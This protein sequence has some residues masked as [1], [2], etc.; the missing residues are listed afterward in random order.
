[1]VQYIDNPAGRLEKLLLDLHAAY[2]NDQQQNHKQAWV[3]V[4]ELINNAS[5]LAAQVQIVG[6]VVALPAEIRESV[7]QL[8]VDDD[9]KEHLLSH[10]VEIEQGMIALLN[11]QSLFAVFNCFATNGIVPRSAAVAALSH[12]SYELHR[13]APEVVISDDDLARI[14][15]M[16]NELMAE[17]AE[18]KLPDVVKRAM[19]NH[20]VALLQAAY[21]VRFAGTQPLDDALFAL[22]G[23]IGRTNGREDLVRVGLWEKFQRAVQA[24]N[25]ML[26]TGQTAAQLGQGI[27]GFL[28]S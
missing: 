9:R 27:A 15:E 20:L 18:A 16:I 5:G 6:A 4:V 19:L 12:C 26:S 8:P 14:I 17:V 10:L 22:S 28:D 3:A 11:R 7:A 2:P 1:M 24:V 21:N 13:S 25:L 23:S